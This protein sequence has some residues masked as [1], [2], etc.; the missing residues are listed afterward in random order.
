[1]R[2]LTAQDLNLLMQ[3]APDVRPRLLDVREHWEFQFAS[4]AGSTHLPMGEIPSRIQEISSK[5]P[6]VVICHHG[7]RSRQVVAYLE[8]QGFENLHNLQGGIDA[9]SR[10][11]DPAVPLY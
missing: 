5:H 3:G 8:Q 1:M 10:E 6:T 7:V 9:W 4:I 2:Q 11:V